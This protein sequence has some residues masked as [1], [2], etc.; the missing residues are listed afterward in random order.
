MTD[1]T[2]RHTPDPTEGASSAVTSTIWR[3]SFKRRMIRL[4]ITC[5]G[6]RQQIRYINRFKEWKHINSY[7]LS[8]RLKSRERDSHL[9]SS[10]TRFKKER[11]HESRYENKQT[12]TNFIPFF[13]HGSGFDLSL[14]RSV[15]FRSRQN[16]PSSHFLN[17]VRFLV[18]CWYGD[19][20]TAVL[21]VICYCSVTVE[22][23]NDLEMLFMFWVLRLGIIITGFDEVTVCS[24]VVEFLWWFVWFYRDFREWMLLKKIYVF[25]M[26][27]IFL[28]IF[29]VLIWRIGERVE[30][31]FVSV[32]GE[33]CHI[34]VRPDDVSLCYFG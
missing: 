8:L 17:L 20:K 25:I 10:K 15:W 23:E 30:K 21:I 28:W 12:G 5:T 16:F 1:Q 31:V 32:I 3:P 27:M 33:F 34:R 19:A 13:T 18:L 29:C 2:K 14:F 24:V 4:G 6:F 22:S 26:F 9:S 7:K 11:C